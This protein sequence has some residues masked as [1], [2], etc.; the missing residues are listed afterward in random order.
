MIGTCFLH[1]FRSAISATYP[2]RHITSDKTD[3]IPL[4]FGTKSAKLP[5]FVRVYRFNTIDFPFCGMPY[6]AWHWNGFRS[7]RQTIFF[8]KLKYSTSY[9]KRIYGDIHENFIFYDFLNDKNWNYNQFD[10]LCAIH[11][12]RNQ[13][14]HVS[15]NKTRTK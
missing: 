15:I 3:K 4:F 12:Q 11:I 5:Q 9:R 14:S 13:V 2:P 6:C 7:K 10:R 1:N 8:S